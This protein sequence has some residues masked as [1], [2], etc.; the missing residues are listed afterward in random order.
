MELARVNPGETLEFLLASD[1]KQLRKLTYRRNAVHSVVVDIIDGRPSATIVERPL[2]KHVV[3]AS[4][5][6]DDS[7]FASAQKAGLSDQITLQLAK[8]FGWDI[9]FAL[10]IRKGDRFKV[11]YEADFLDGKKYHDGDI[12]AAEFINNGHTYH[13]FRYTTPEGEEDYYDTEGHNMRKAFL[14]TPVKFTRISS[15]FTRRRWHP[16]LKRWRSH[17]GVDYAAPRGTPIKAAGKGKII[18]RGWKGGYGRVI[19]IQ[20]SRKYTTVYGHMSAFN[21]KLRN[22]SHVKQGQVIGYVGSSGLA[23]GPHLHYELRVNG[24]HTNPLK[25]KLPKTLKLPSRYMSDFRESIKP[26][27]ARFEH[28]D[29][30]LVAH[31]E[32]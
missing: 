21:K 16:V 24:V 12:L 32:D 5:S 8:V 28:W 30:T 27:V 20:H 3:D 26:F 7:L 13:A 17:K 23:T 10:E 19:M 6:I 9:D 22:G 2:E 31:A 15:R 1:T 29:E 18:F 11:I 4:G 14:R 25:I